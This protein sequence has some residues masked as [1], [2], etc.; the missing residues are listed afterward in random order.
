MCDGISPWK[1]MSVDDVPFDPDHKN[2]LQN[3][4]T[5]ATSS[6]PK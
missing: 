2:K 5:I 1:E 4:L 3:L 6:L